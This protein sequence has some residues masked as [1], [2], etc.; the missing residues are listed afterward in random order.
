MPSQTADAAP[1]PLPIRRAEFARRAGRSKGRITEACRPG[2][3]LATACLL[4][5]EIDVRHPS[6]AVWAKARG[7]DP[8]VFDP[9]EAIVEPAAAPR[10]PRTPQG[11]AAPRP[12]RDAYDA[13]SLRKKEAEVKRLELRNARDEGRLISLEIVRLAVFGYL[14]RLS[15]QLLGP[16][17]QTLSQRIAAGARSNLTDPELRAIAREMFSAELAEAKRHATAGIR[18]ASRSAKS[19]E[20]PETLDEI[21][22]VPSASNHP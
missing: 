12:S 6:V 22:D 2:G 16:V 8:T 15:R 9:T 1:A 10:K 21:Q 7:L 19:G 3:P 4:N 20:L 17:S 18:Q 14:D 13:L 5:G 11:S